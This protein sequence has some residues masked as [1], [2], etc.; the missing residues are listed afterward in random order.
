MANFDAKAARVDYAGDG[1]DEADLAPSPLEQATR[2]LE[3]AL[4]HGTQ[5]ADTLEPMALSVAT[6]DAQG[7]P[8]VRTV[9]M[10]GLD[11]RGPSFFT[12]M[13][14]AKGRELAGTPAIAAALTW[15]WLYRAI[16]FRGT[17]TPLPDAE[18]AAYFASRPWGSR[19]SAWAS[20]Q[21]QVVDSR[22]DLERQYA[23]AAERF[24]DHGGPDDV[25]VPPFWGGY[26]ITC[27]EVEFWAGRRSRLHDRLVFERVGPGD[28]GEPSAWRVVRRQP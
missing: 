18:V 1:L 13:T 15:P 26:R 24:P 6:V 9:L 28:L 5:S 8:N 10:R 23:V 12:N 25:P 3:N 21:S 19:V 7:A 2:W 14:S 22:A 20:E 4:A 27:R 17:A 11:A 16:R